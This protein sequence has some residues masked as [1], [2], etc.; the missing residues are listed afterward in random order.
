MSSEIFREIGAGPPIVCFQGTGGGQLSRGYELLAQRFRVVAFELPGPGTA[1]AEELARRMNAAVAALGIERYS[2][3]GSAS[4]SK[5]ALWMAIERPAAVDAI[6]LSAPEDA[7]EKRAAELPH[8]VLVLF[9]TT[10]TVTPPEEAR[11]YGD[12]LQHGHV[13][14][15]YGAGHAIDADRPEA[16][17][18][19][20]GDFL[21]RKEEFLVN[22][23][24]GLV[25]PKEHR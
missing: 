21:T 10:D 15:I 3:L 24:S 2:V 19:V 7:L 25:H 14:M 22:I 5:V 13:M 8:P 1:S 6:V 23:T 11:R 9:G 17:A 20:V 4:S 18:S 16:F 12:L